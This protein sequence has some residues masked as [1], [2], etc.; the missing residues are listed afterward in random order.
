MLSIRQ[1]AQQL[2]CSRETVRKAIIN[3]LL[4]GQKVHAKLWAIEADQRDLLVFKARLEYLSQIRKFRSSL[5]RTLWQTGRLK[6]R[7]KRQVQMVIIERLRLKRPL[8]IAMGQGLGTRTAPVIWRDD[9]EGESHCP[10]CG[11]A[12]KVR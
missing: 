2:G 10:A 6:P 7:R 9:K 11:T 5:M 8:T 3:G 4:R 1:L 12:L